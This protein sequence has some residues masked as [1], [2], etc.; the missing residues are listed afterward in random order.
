[1]T[2]HDDDP[3]SHRPDVRGFG[4]PSIDDIFAAATSGPK[5]SPSPP[6]GPS[7]DTIACAGCGA[8]REGKQRYGTCS[9]CGTPWFAPEEP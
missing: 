8:P 1:M 7:V 2:T 4:P 3:P 6:G 9:R 5:A